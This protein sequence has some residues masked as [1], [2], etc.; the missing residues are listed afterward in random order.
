MKARLSSVLKNPDS[1]K[2][3]ASQ[4]ASVCI[5]DNPDFVSTWTGVP[6]DESGQAPV[7][8]LFYR[9]C[10]DASLYGGENVDIAL[11]RYVDIFYGCSPNQRMVQ[12]LIGIEKT[13][14]DGPVRMFEKVF[15]P[16]GTGGGVDATCSP[17]KAGGYAAPKKTSNGYVPG[18]VGT[19]AGVDTSS[20]KEDHPVSQKILK[21]IAVL[22]E[23]AAEG[24]WLKFNKNMSSAT[25]ES[26]SSKLLKTLL[27]AQKNLLDKQNWTIHS[28]P[29][30]AKPAQQK[31]PE[32][33]PF[34]LDDVI[35]TAPAPTLISDGSTWKKVGGK[36]G[37][38]AGGTYEMGGKKYYV[39]TPQDT[40]R[41]INEVLTNKLYQLAGASTQPSHL[42]QIEGKTAV[43][44]EWVEMNGTGKID[45]NN[46]ANQIKAQEDFAAHVWLNNRDAIGAGSENPEMNIIADK[47]GNFKI[48]DT[49]GGLGYKG[50]GGGGKKDFGV[51]V[52]E[53]DTMV[54]PSV[55]P[56]MAKV[57]GGMTDQQKL[58][59]IK[60]LDHIT[61]EDVTKLAK[62][63][64]APE[65]IGSTL[66]TR[67]LSLRHTRDML[68]KKLKTPAPPIAVA[69]GSDK[70][71]LLPKEIPTAP[72]F[73]S[74]NPV[75]IK[76]NTDSVAAIVEAA[77]TGNV[78]QV[79][80]IA[81]KSKSPKVIDF[82][83]EVASAMKS[84]ANDPVP[85]AA[86]ASKTEASIVSKAGSAEAKTGLDKIG[87]YS[88]LDKLPPHAIPAISTPAKKSSAQW[89]LGK[90]FY[91]NSTPETK[92]ALKSYTGG[93]YSD[94]NHSL[95]KGK[96]S[97]GAL[98]VAKALMKA[99]LLK[100]G[101]VLTRKHGLEDED[102]KKLLLA[103][104]GTIIQE[105]A[106]LSTSTKES[107]WSGSVTL[108]ITVGKGVRGLP[109]KG[110]SNH[111][112]EN[113]VM[114][115]PNTRFLVTNVVKS[116]S[117]YSTT[118]HVIALPTEDNQCCPP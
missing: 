88:V 77:K 90:S 110:F 54:D 42:V 89:A 72:Q 108:S 59:S 66:V 29:A 23:A 60:K 32:A 65:E 57:F 21:K 86:S 52:K 13:E 9:L 56:T 74:K 48:I 36:L 10:I 1:L 95:R 78:I 61:H 15:C 44:S 45:F 75:T 63:M 39:K 83:N 31:E 93:G 35:D 19:F 118:V 76:E 3:E 84:K 51:A 12:D 81:A 34:T 62:E 115:P 103:G 102:K 64:G 117:G 94:M 105:K 50:M 96:P 2:S 91:F 53:W 55:N 112:S 26:S 80:A 113:E 11:Q 47:D 14:E 92:S 104:P 43:A 85:V 49:G 73:I 17:G 100:K 30:G 111:P 116:S 24:N 20:W 69:T 25:P 109:A 82:A 37:T 99:P 28:L 98:L 67:L 106:I 70:H 41:A 4:F 46:K 5:P 33:D 114:L 101:S 68:E 71:K 16:T 58:D 40:D 97:P 18:T 87:H 107:A 22:E 7:K 38:E 8:A 79:A 6:V 27:T